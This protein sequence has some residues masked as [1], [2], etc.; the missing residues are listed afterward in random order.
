MKRGLLVLGLLLMVV[1]GW[2]ML[3]GG[4]P[5][6]KWEVRNDPPTGETIVA[7]GDSLT[8][9]YG[10]QGNEAWP[11]LV[12]RA[13]GRPVINAGVSGNT[14]ADGLRR[15]ERD[16]IAHNPRVVIVMLGGN[17]MLRRLSV[18][19]QFNNLREIVTRIQDSGALVILAGV[20]GDGLLFSGDHGPRYEALARETGSVYVRDVLSGVRGRNMQSDR[21][22]PTPQGHERMARAILDEAEPYL[23]R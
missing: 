8:A 1:L 5:A 23:R 17:D 9:G 22:H 7:L 13:I 4:G 14:T 2:R 11:A 19:Q 6:T 10:V 20:E 16:V 15:V 21:I 3:A 12:S 18:E